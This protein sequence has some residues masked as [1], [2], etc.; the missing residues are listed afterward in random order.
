M[1]RGRCGWV[2]AC[3]A[4][5]LALIAPPD[6]SAVRVRL[7]AK[8]GSPA[9][10]VI[11]RDGF[12][13]LD[14]RL[15]ESRL[16]LRLDDLLPLDPDAL[17]PAREPDVVLCASM[18]WSINA[19]VAAA[20]TD[21]ANLRFVPGTDDSALD[22][23]FAYAEAVNLWGGRLD[24]RLGRLVHS[25][26][27]GWRSDDGASLRLAPSPA[28]R[29]RLLGGLENVRGLRLSASPFAPDGVERWSGEGQGAARYAEPVE[30]RHRPATQ[31][32]LDGTAGPVGY[33]VA[34]RRTW[35]SLDGGVAEETGGFAV[36]VSGGPLTLR[37]AARA[38]LA[39]GF[40]SEASARAALRP[41]GG[42]HRLEAQYG[43]YRPSFDLESIFIVF[44]SD[45]LHEAVL[46]WRFPLPGVLSGEVW[47][48]A[49]RV[50]PLAEDGNAETLVGP[51]GDL[52]GGLGVF[53]RTDRYS[54]GAR[55]KAMRG[56]SA[57][58]AAFDIELR[59]DPWRRWS[60]FGAGSAWQYEDR[61]RAGGPGVGGGGR[62]GASVE[63]VEGVGIEAEA[64][65]AHDRREGTTFAVFAWLDLGVT[66]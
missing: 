2:G 34:Y 60:L 65:V 19:G 3:L 35:R 33:D 51:F 9:Y 7:E 45:P 1:L 59:A 41:A 49:R 48:A 14:E 46:R 21:P 18:R 11:G 29:L 20:S 31:V 6:A 10:P 64:Q 38:D 25:G 13:V 55:W 16:F 15:I 61:L 36:D 56:T 58:L 8:T 28:L 40:V 57:S 4:P 54:G 47:T 27:L 23:L 37:G 26:P 22:V 53:L 12:V 50:E 17:D 44:A 32:S 42:E 52:G 62:A 63:I 30:P 43:Y 66:L 24:A 39:A 5:A